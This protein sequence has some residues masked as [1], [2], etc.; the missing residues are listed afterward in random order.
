MSDWVRRVEYA[1]GNRSSHSH[2][3]AETEWKLS[4]LKSFNESQAT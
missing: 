3:E 2:A 4:S 1:I